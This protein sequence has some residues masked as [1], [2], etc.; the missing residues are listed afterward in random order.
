MNVIPSKQNLQEA[1]LGENYGDVKGVARIFY[2]FISMLL[3]GLITGIFIVLSTKAV[4]SAA[5]LATGILLV[6]VAWHLVSVRM[7]EAAAIW[8]GILLLLMNTILATMELG[9]H[10]ISNFVFPVILIIA[11]LVTSKRT[12]FFLTILTVLC[13]A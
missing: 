13:I 1:R 5:I 12:M 2:L 8:L 7:F 4:F 9:I 3:I 6:L 10:N 11:S